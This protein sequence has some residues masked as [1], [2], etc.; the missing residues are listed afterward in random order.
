[1][2]TAT[3]QPTPDTFQSSG[4]IGGSPSHF[5]SVTGDWYLTTLYRSSPNQLSGRVGQ[6][7]QGY[8]DG[9]ARV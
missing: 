5:V 8:I 2:P 9:D 3:S 7:H 1:M 6:G 4:I